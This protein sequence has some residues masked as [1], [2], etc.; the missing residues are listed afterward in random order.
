MIDESSEG[1]DWRNSSED[2]T[3][4]TIDLENDLKSYRAEESNTKEDFID[5]SHLWEIFGD[6]TMLATV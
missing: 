6:Q 1:L 5:K 2:D 3:L 4:D